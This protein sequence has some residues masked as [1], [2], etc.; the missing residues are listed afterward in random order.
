MPITNN[1]KTKHQKNHVLG[2]V[3]CFTT[4]LEKDDGWKT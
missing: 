3:T 2:A 1:E 4:V